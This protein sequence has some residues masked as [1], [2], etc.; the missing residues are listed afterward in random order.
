MA[1]SAKQFLQKFNPK[2]YE[3]LEQQHNDMTAADH[4]A[5]QILVNNMKNVSMNG[6]Q[7]KI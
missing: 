3:E 4:E 6:H 1:P 2:Y 5:A 7:T